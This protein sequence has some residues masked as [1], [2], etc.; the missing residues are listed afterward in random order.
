ML[1]PIKL[2]IFEN[3]IIRYKH[4]YTT[5]N[6]TWKTI[7]KRLVTLPVTKVNIT[8]LRIP[9]VKASLKPKITNVISMTIFDNPNLAPGATK[10]T[11]IMDSMT[12]NPRPTET[13]NDR[14]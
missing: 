1:T 12:L 10:G 2:K 8:D 3:L 9:T 11:G 6:G 5:K 7:K 14:N 13:N 4:Q